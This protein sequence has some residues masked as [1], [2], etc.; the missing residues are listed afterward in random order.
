VLV[1][2][3]NE[4]NQ[5]VVRTVLN[6][7]GIDPLIVADG[8]AVVQAWSTGAWDLVLMDIQMPHLDGLK[9]CQQIRLFEQ[10]QNKD[11]LPVIALTASVLDEDKIAAQEAG[12][13]GFASKPI[14]F[15][16]LC[17]EIARVLAIEVREPLSLQVQTGAGDLLLNLQKALQLWGNLATYLPQLHAFL[18]QQRQTLLLVA[19]QLNCGDYQAV[20]YQAHA[21][22]GVSANLGLD[23]LS[24]ACAELEQAARQHQQQR[25]SELLQKILGCWPKFEAEYQKLLSEQPAAAQS[26]AHQFSDQQLGALLDRLQQSLLRHELDD[27]GIEQLSYYNGE[28]QT[29]LL[30]LLDAINDFDFSLALQL[31]EQLQQKLAGEQL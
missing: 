5:R 9:A 29:I 19:E 22:K 18:Q 16:A 31:L 15:A 24:K 13:Q 20:Q 12:M 1:A 7:L 8:E 28:H 6:A 4:A 21:I 2:E 26:Q 11:L 25:A 3:D 10:Q 17:F 30:T 23:P 14:D 27:Q